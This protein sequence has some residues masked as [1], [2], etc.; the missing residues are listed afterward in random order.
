MQ[1]ALFHVSEEPE[2][3]QFE[4]RMPPVACPLQ[5][6]LVFAIRE[7]LLHNYL[8]P[9]DCPR[10]TFYAV[11]GSTPEDVE[12]LIGLT[13]ARHV[14]AIESA[15]IERVLRT[16][17][18]LYRLPGDTFE[19]LDEGAGYYVSREAVEPLHVERV[20]SIVEELCR[21][22]VELRI[23]PSLWKLRDAVTASTLQFSHIRM[24]NAA[25]RL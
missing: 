14:V 22:D 20:D 2:I 9:R 12:R 10:V 4:P 19:S 5:E 13:D 1:E 6:P 17:L 15:W 25:P 3:R 21:R 11:P 8:L 23:T 16:R 18:Y 7:G 24:R